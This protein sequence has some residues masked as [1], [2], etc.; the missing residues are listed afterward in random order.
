MFSRH[1]NQQIFLEKESLIC[2]TI[3]LQML[4]SCLVLKRIIYQDTLYTMPKYVKFDTNQKRSNSLIKI[5]Q[6]AFLKSF[7]TAD[8]ND[9][10]TA[11]D[12]LQHARKIAEQHIKVNST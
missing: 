7:T 8:V 12:R 6:V 4:T 3:V 10:Q 5:K 2:G 9:T 1:E 11:V